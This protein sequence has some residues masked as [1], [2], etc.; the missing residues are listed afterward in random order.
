[1]E[2]EIADA[3]HQKDLASAASSIFLSCRPISRKGDQTPAS[4]S[5]EIKAPLEAAVREGLA[6]F[7]Q[8]NL[9][10][11][12]RMIAS[13][14]RALRLYSEH[15]P[16]LDGDEEVPPTRAMQEAARVVAEEE[17]SR[18]S[19]GRITVDDLDG[20]SR[21]A[22][23]ALGING[24]GAFAF[25]DA[26]QMSKSL[27]LALQHKSGNYRADPEMVAYN[28][29]T[30]PAK[31]APLAKKGSKL[32]LLAPSERDRQ[33]L[34]RPQTAWDVLGGLIIQYR[35]GGVVA[36]RNYLS[37]NG[38][39]ESEALRGL[40]QVWADECGDEDLRREACLIDYEL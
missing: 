11:V 10:P 5:H 20:E 16:V 3:T 17:V 25:D 8:L 19:G 29:E 12:D 26:L 2:S 32:R 23:I 15:W 36:A 35:E 37:A 4:W 24:L 28:N 34:D 27:N 33:R 39:A 13:W 9:S 22:V 6:E 14:G 21:L 38:R 30:D 18:I 1:M 40:L 31:A 7:E